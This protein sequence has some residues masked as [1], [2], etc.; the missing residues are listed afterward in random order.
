MRLSA[1]QQKRVDD[2]R[3]LCKRR[4]ITIKPFGV[5]WRL[6]GVGVDVLTAELHTMDLQDLKIFALDG[7][8]MNRLPE[9]GEPLSG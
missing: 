1:K 7:W 4:N 5:G 8:R 2:F 9:L 3:E 6:R